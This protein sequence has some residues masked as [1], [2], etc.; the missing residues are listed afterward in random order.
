[1]NIIKK[2]IAILIT[3]IMIITCQLPILAASTENTITKK[4]YTLPNVSSIGIAGTSRGNWHDRQN[5]GIYMKAGSSFEIR[6]TNLTINQDLNLDCLNNDSQT[7]KSYKIPKNGDWVTI[8]VDNDS[9]PFIRTVYGL[10]TEPTVEIRNEKQTEELTYYYYKGNE[11]EFFEKWKN[12]NHSYAV[13]ENDVA[14]F[15]V[16][17][18]DRDSIV[19]TNGNNYNFKSIDEMLEYYHNFVEQFDRFLGLSYDTDNILNKNIRTKFFVKANK[20]GAGAAYYSGNHTA[21]NGDSISGY[22]SK[23]WLNLHEFGHGY[24]GSLANQDLA[25]VDVMNNILAHYFQITFLN[26]NDGGWLGNKLKIEESI[27]NA[28]EKASNFN[29]LS[30]QQKLYMFVD[31]LDKI[32]P[33]KSMTYVHSKYREYVSQGKQYNASDMFAKSFSEV[34]GY[35]VIPYLNSFK[36]TPSEDIQTEIYEKDLPCVYYLRDLVDT[37]EKTGQIRKELNLDGKY[38]L[39]SNEDIAKYN[40]NGNLTINISIED[41]EQIKNKKIYIKDG[42]KIVKEILVDSTNLK[43]ENLPVGIYE[44]ELPNTK[45]LAYEHN[46]EYVVVKENNDNI[47]NIEYKKI[48]VNTMASDTQI[49][50]RGLGDDQFANA[51]IDLENKKMTINSANT[52]PHVY[53]NDEYANI[54]VFDNKGNLVY[55]KSYI[56]DI[57][58]P[59]ND[60]INIDIGYSIKIKHREAAGRLVFKSKCL[61]EN[62]DFKNANNSQTTYT[63]TKYG[64]QKE[65]ISDEEQYQ[66]YKTKVDKYI[67]KLQGE[68]TQEKQDNKYKYFIQKNKLLSNILDLNEDDKNT[69]LTAN[70]KL[71]NGS[72][73]I[74]EGLDTLEFTVG[75]K[76]DINLDKFK[77]TDVEDGNIALTNENVTN[78]VEVDEENKITSAGNYEAE[79]IVYDSDNN[80][81][82]KKITINVKEQQ[83]SEDQKPNEDKQKPSEDDQKPNEDN[84]KPSEDDQKPNEDNQQPS[85]DDQKPNEDKQKPSKDNQKL[86]EETIN[87]V[88]NTIKEGILPK[89]GK[90][91]N[92]NIIFA[93]IGIATLSIFIILQKKTKKSTKSVDKKVK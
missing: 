10:E 67:K 34:S 44:I 37:D 9:V 75:D 49:L 23:G 87:K 50:F 41:F 18:K 7:E 16:P 62:E 70:S 24:E 20:H 81:A 3:S 57:A 82:I 17:V 73:P 43:I 13:I 84:Q 35:N 74:I 69:Y 72:A 58:S 71:I 59:S 38:A 29:E 19:K 40:M 66:K 93:G 48:N 36:V 4:L 89:T 8:S 1:M 28:R 92:L 14:T 31:L 91:S 88:D 86:N 60:T 65:G 61:N 30:Y 53:F 25:L 11:Q 47:K 45:N 39:V 2:T 12:N 33:E 85:E 52:K 46:Y 51:E 54:Q 77:C 32:G 79:L 5:L 27:K 76:F 64:L 21:Q 78:N 90:A 42:S 15:L 83:P 26:E 56:G 63:I 6:Q 55:E 68:I 22:L 80:K